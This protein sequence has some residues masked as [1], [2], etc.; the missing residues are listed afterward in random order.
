MVR[1][2]LALS[3][4]TAGSVHDGI[5]LQFPINAPGTMGQRARRPARPSWMCAAAT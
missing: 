4:A 5:V 1:T 2:M 3:L